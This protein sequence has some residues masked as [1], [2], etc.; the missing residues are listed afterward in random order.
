MNSE[1]MANL[2]GEGKLV[3]MIK[4]DQSGGFW[5]RANSPA[6]LTGLELECCLKNTEDGRT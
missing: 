1:L 6:S 3:L 2:F 4:P 5:A